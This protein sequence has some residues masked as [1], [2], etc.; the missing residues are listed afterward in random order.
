MSKAREVLKCVEAVFKPNRRLLNTIK[1]PL[2]KRRWYIEVE[3]PDL[4]EYSGGTATLK[5]KFQYAEDVWD[6]LTDKFNE[7]VSKLHNSYEEV[8]EIDFTELADWVY[9]NFDT[10]AS[11]SYLYSKFSGFKKEMEKLAKEY[12]AI[13]WKTK[14]GKKRGK[15]IEKI[16]LNKVRAQLKKV[17]P[18]QDWGDDAFHIRDRI[19]SPHEEW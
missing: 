15:E 13:D 19:V 12:R 2:K 4:L 8:G 6:F 5:K 10:K 14:E 16:V 11:R 18:K 7:M 17:D 3:V 9:G 1:K